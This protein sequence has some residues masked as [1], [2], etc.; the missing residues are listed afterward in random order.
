[1]S[2]LR[3]L[4]HGPRLEDPNELL[5]FDAWAWP[6]LMV[7]VR[8]RTLPPGYAGY[9]VEDA[10][11]KPVLDA[12][13]AAGRTCAV[14][15]VMAQASAA[16]STTATLAGGLAAGVAGFAALGAEMLVAPL[17]SPAG[18]AEVQQWLTR[19]DAASLAITRHLGLA[20]A[21]ASAKLHASTVSRVLAPG[22]QR[23]VALCLPSVPSL[24]LSFAAR[25][26]EVLAFLGA[27]ETRRRREA[28]LGWPALLARDD[29]PLASVPGQVAA[30]AR[31]YVAWIEAS[32]LAQRGAGAVTE[33]LWKLDAPSMVADLTRAV[34]ATPKSQWAPFQAR[35][36][37]FGALDAL[38]SDIPV[39]LI[40]S[41][42]RGYP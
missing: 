9:P 32:G 22:W 35:G 33:L 20:G 17:E 19:I 14:G 15:A 6:T 13:A 38:R 23:T 2:G 16:S 40:S 7:H 4:V 31:E 39:A 27:D 30:A 34:G 24:D 36:L 42:P 1:M 3:Y 18:D 29:V 21:L 37:A 25:S 11:P 8:P 5:F 28:L 12:L 26:S 10:W 41:R